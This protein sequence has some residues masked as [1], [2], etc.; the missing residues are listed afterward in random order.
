MVSVDPLP[1]RRELP[2]ARLLLLPFKAMAAVTGAAVAAVTQPA[3]LAVGSCGAVAPLLV[4]P[5]AAE[6]VRRGRTLRNLRAEHARHTACLE[7]RIAG[8]GEDGRAPVDPVTLAVAR[9]EPTPSATPE[10]AALLR[11]CSAPLS[12]AEPPARLNLPFSVVAVPLADLLTAG[13]VQ[14]RAPIVRRAVPGRSLLE[15]VMRGLRQLRHP[16]RTT[17][18]GPVAAHGRGRRE[19]RDGGRFRRRQDHHGRL[20]QR[21]QTADHRGDRD[22]GRGGRGRRLRLQDRDGHHRRHGLRPH[23]HHRTAGAPPL[24]HPGQE[25]RAA[26]DLPEDVPIVEC[27]A[28][29]RASGRDVLMTLMRFLP[30]LAVSGARL[31]S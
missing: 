28:R 29:R 10:Q 12:A 18:A 21:D 3:R 5:T 8:E 27:D 4:V 14:A 7:R 15:A 19:D 17:D 30:S 22:P 24:R 13:P 1:G 25:L 6:A 16:P 31:P 11:L 26:L 2:Y 9:A 20:G 23:R